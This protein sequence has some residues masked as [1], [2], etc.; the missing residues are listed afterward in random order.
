[1]SV[2]RLLLSLSVVLSAALSTAGLAAQDLRSIMAAHEQRMAAVRQAE[3]PQKAY[4]AAMERVSKE[5]AAHLKKSRGK[6]QVATRFALL[7]LLLNRGRMD[8][9]KALLEAFDPA[10]AGPLSCA[11]AAIWASNLRMDNLRDRFLDAAL[12]KEM[13]LADRMQIYSLI[14]A[15]MALPKRSEKLFGKAL[16]AAESA[17]DKATVLWYQAA[18]IRE[19][20]DLKE[21]S[22]D[23]ALEKLAK[24]FPKTRYGRIAHDR[25]QAMAFQVG[26]AALDYAVPGLDGG[27]LSTRKARG[28][29]LLIC[30]IQTDLRA[31][32]KDLAAILALQEQF[33][34]DKFQVHLLALDEDAK[35]TRQRLQ[36]LA[37][38]LPAAMAGGW[39]GDLALRFRVEA[40]PQVLLLDS[41]GKI[42][43]MNYLL[44]D[45]YSQ[46]KLAQ[47]LGGILAR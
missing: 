1:M 25:L 44:R 3:D 45:A 19:R 4:E 37:P 42:A 28:K 29:P 6:E 18:A 26:G 12:Q 39:E 7:D 35:A 14:G 5:L 36:K 43:G 8:Q 40:S 23:E 32:A 24:A 22:Y 9:G 46:K 30:F 47:A 34:A 2:S 33:G 41:A 15:Q 16:A 21:G 13:P 38:K 31:A 10:T 20:E 17:E 11:E 27:E